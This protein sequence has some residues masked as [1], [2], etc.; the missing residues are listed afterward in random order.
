M[1]CKNCNE[2]I[3]DNA[4]FC[5]NCGA[6]VVKSR[7]TFNLLFTEFLS[8]FFGWDTRFF[9]TLKTMLTKPEVV[10]YEYINGVR[11]RYVNPFAFFAIGAAISLITFNFFADEYVSINKNSFVSFEKV[12]EQF[13]PKY[14]ELSE[15]KKAEII[16]NQK[17][18]QE[19]QIKYLLKY[20][21]VFSFILLPIYAFIAFLTYRKPYNY[22][23]HIIIN[24]YVQGIT[25]L[26]TNLFFILAVFLSPKFFVYSI[27]ITIGFY[28]YAYQRLYSLTIGKSLIKLLKFIGILLSITII[29]ATFSFIIAI[30][31]G[32]LKAS[33]F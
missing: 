30:I 12:N 33:G 17:A 6:K 25:F 2:T 28:L 3:E 16:D 9:I 15:V 4:S 10:L 27:I 20:F 31:I 8:N 11:K 29:I 21:N 23:E 1:N 5:D 19:K 18:N 7:I 14:N 13:I 24:A 22:G 32:F 26:T